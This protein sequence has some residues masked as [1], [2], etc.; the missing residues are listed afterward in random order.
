MA[1]RLSGSM[2]KGLR[3]DKRSVDSSE[4]GNIAE[5]ID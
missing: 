4:T 3:V 2:V 5:E 1:L